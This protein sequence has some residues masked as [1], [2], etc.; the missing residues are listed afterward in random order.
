MIRATYAWNRYKDNW[1][2]FKALRDMGKT[3]TFAQAEA[4]R[5]RL[6]AWYWIGVVR[7]ESR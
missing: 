6:L 3:W 2:A 5:C 1:T 4:E 7:G